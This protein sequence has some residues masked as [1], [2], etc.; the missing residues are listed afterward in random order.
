MDVTIS[1]SHRAKL[2]AK[3]SVKNKKRK[4]RTQMSLNNY[5]PLLLLF[6]ISSLQLS[7]ISFTQAPE[8]NQF[9]FWYHA[10]P[11][12]KPPWCLSTL[13]SIQPTLIWLQSSFLLSHASSSTW[14]SPISKTMSIITLITL[15]HTTLFSTLGTCLDHPLFSHLHLPKSILQ[16]FSKYSYMQL[17]TIQSQRIVCPG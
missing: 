11:T 10:I 16:L 4:K 12:L 3:W 15:H 13:H 7:Q 2:K 9:K 5:L 17:R 6:K 8:W 14:M 1:K